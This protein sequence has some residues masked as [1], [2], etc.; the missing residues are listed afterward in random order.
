M[1]LLSA[2][3]GKSVI[4]EG[5]A[6]H[7]VTASSTHGVLAAREQALKMANSYC[8]RSGQQAVVESYDDKT[9]GGVVADPT[10]IAVFA[11]TVPNTT[12]MSG[13]A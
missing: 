9:L 5:T 11:C 12:T 3:G 10:S 13:Q 7:S 4:D 1:L 8:A 2:C 6:R